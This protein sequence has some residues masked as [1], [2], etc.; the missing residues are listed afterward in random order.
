M[1]SRLCANILNLAKLLIN[2]F[3]IIVISENYGSEFEE[4]FLEL[5]IVFKQLFSLRFLTIYN[6]HKKTSI[7][8]FKTSIYYFSYM[9]K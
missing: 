1:I 7:H 6:P 2:S 9:H 5:T 3:E 8:H 4:T